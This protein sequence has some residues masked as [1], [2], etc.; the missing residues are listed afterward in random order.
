MPQSTTFNQTIL[1][2]ADATSL[3]HK[4][5]VLGKMESGSAFQILA[6]QIRNEDA[7]HVRGIST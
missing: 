6:V 2:T 7:R 3:H 1:D 5:E 4:S